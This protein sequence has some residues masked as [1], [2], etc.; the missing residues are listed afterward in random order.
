MPDPTYGHLRVFAP[1]RG[2]HGVPSE[3]LH[4]LP[5]LLE[6]FDLLDPIGG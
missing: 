6:P 3:D 5:D 1:N 2:R 4:H